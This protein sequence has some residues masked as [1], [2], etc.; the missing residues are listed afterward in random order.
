MDELQAVL[1]D[2][3]PA[4]DDLEKLPYLQVCSLFVSR[5]LCAC[6]CACA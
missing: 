3:P 1:G 5:I 2:R 4:Y 6:A